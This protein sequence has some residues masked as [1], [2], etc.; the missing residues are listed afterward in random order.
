MT[1]RVLTQNDVHSLTTPARVIEVGLDGFGIS[2]DAG[3]LT[4]D[5]S[6]CTAVAL[7]PH[8]PGGAC[9]L[10]HI[11]ANPKL[12]P[13]GEDAVA[14]HAR[15]LWHTFT[16]NLDTGA[17][18]DAIVFGGQN[19]VMPAHSVSRIISD[20][21]FESVTHSG[22]VVS[23]DDRRFSSERGMQAVINPA[24]REI[25]VAEDFHFYDM[26]ALDDAPRQAGR[27]L[28]LK[29]AKKPSTFTI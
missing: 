19:G 14:R 28:E 4:Q 22:F 29:G 5:V 20:T 10:L 17:G 12:F 6:V 8:D 3:L 21:V 24:S 23:T 11:Y 27:P 25:A 16:E 15:H 26:D 13:L 9:A 18:Y 1:W 7:L 2:R